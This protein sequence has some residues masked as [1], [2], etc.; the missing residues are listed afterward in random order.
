M[1]VVFFRCRQKP[2]DDV[3]V[4]VS[5]ERQ[6]R[7]R[8][9]QRASAV[10]KEEGSSF[11][12]RSFVKRRTDGREAF[13]LL[14]IDFQIIFKR[15]RDGFW[16]SPVFVRITGPTDRALQV[17]DAVYPTGNSAVKASIDYQYGTKSG[18]IDG[19]ILTANE[20]RLS[21]F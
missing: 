8:E 3:I 14:T 11:Q 10:F 15:C 1:T 4:A 18:S 7:L 21:T 16:F 12:V 6:G 5:P 17:D 13:L 19:L 2:N 9:D 20:A